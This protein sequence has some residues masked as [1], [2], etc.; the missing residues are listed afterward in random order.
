MYMVVI[1]LERGKMHELEKLSL[2]LSV[3]R[4]NET[5]GFCLT[6]KNGL[7]KRLKKKSEHR[8]ILRICKKG[9]VSF[10]VRTGK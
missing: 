1:V 10:S 5:K 2:S 7:D 8:L 3:H 9:G 6:V 4:R